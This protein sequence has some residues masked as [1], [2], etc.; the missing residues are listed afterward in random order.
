ME[1]KQGLILIFFILPNLMFILA[2][3][4]DTIKI[5]KQNRE[6]HK[7]KKQV[8]LIKEELQ[9][10]HFNWEYDFNK[11]FEKVVNF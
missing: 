2:G 11:Q 10:Q 7:A 8:R 1:L 6:Q 3:I 4:I 9:R 5:N